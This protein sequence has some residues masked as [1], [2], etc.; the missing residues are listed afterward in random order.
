MSGARRKLSAIDDPLAFGG[1]GPA[2]ERDGERVAPRP[3][4]TPPARELPA[5]FVRLPP[6]EFDA[7]SRAAFELKEHKR[8]LVSAL[9]WRHVTPTGAGL[10]DLRRL[11]D[12]YRRHSG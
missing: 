7:L 4:V 12:E 9:V 3:P 10:A 8:E 5:L 2:A 6:S 1:D 11:V